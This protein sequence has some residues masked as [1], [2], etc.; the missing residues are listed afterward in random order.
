MPT[1]GWVDEVFGTSMLVE[2]AG[3]SCEVECWRQLVSV[4]A[5]KAGRK[6]KRAEKGAV[7]GS[8]APDG[9]SGQRWR[10]EGPVRHFQVRVFNVM[11]E[12]FSIK[13]QG[14]YRNRLR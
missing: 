13:V 1:V 5:A 11:S 6:R 2:D 4:K 3:A 8:G 7:H 14:I 12:S 9:S 10:F